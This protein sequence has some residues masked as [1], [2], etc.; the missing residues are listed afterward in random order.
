MLGIEDF[1]PTEVAAI[2]SIRKALKKHGSVYV[3][4][5]HGIWLEFAGRRLVHVA[6]RAGR[7]YVNPSTLAGKSGA[8]YD[9]NLSDPDFV[10][11]AVQ[12][13]IKEAFN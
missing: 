3:H 2:D 7:L 11:K 8:H 1:N 13:V 10:D 4:I 5:V 6:Y 12:R 9:V